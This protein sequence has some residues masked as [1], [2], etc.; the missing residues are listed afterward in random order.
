[1]AEPRSVTHWFELLRG[2]D[3]AAAQRLWERYFPQLVGLARARLRSGAPIDDP[4]DVALS[5]FASFCRHAERGRFPQLSDRDGLW[6]LLVTLT[7]RKAAH[8][9]RAQRRAKRG[10]GVA[11]VDLD[12]NELVGEEP[13]PEFAAQIAEE[14]RRLLDRLA[15]DDLCRIAVLRME[16]CS[17]KE[18][19]T[20]MDR[21]HRTIERKLGLIRQIWEREV[22][23]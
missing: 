4:E 5:A 12:L 2:G 1:M 16:G 11:V 17:T 22:P 3:G 7:V 14:Y 21:A 6:R 23:P 9:A 20:E 19:A 8:A 10:G 13:T 15:D 18:I